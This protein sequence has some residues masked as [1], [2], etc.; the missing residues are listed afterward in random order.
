MR[1]GIDAS[2][3]FGWRGPSRNIKNLI[4]TL[5]ELDTKNKYFLFVPWE[6][7]FKLE[8][9][10]NFTWVVVKKKRL[11]PW[12]NISLPLSV[13]KHNIDIFI[14]PQSNFWLWRPTKT[15]VI[16]RAAKIVNF[17]SNK[18]E[19][20]SSYLKE[21]RFTKIADRIISVS[22]FNAIQMQLLYS[23]EEEKISVIYNGV[24]PV[25][26]NNK[27]PPFSKYGNY[28]LCVGGTER[29]KN[30][31][32]LLESY[33]ILISR[34]IKEK[35]V[36]VGGKYAPIEQGVEPLM[37]KIEML[38]LKK[39]VIFHGIERDSEK[40]A[41]L[42]KGARAFVHP[43]LLET[44]GLVCVEAM[45]CGCPVISSRMPSMPEILGDAAEYFDPYDVNEI[46]DK[47]EKVLKDDDLRESLIAKGKERVKRYSWENSARKLFEL[48]EDVVKK[49]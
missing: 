24:D 29:M 5:L 17:L 45:A 31:E 34:G 4:R 36:L 37:E 7:T 32:R 46:A 28:I 40:L 15:I 30:I 20:V 44:F 2:G 13:I 16:A 10:S 25:F 49:N 11:I 23:I 47:I 1:I 35:L 26:L 43:S 27:I 48:I 21:L 14:F 6:P 19:T 22:E 9:K 3:T 12:L 42:Y 18:L 8:E 39:H 41:S 38:Y 33:K